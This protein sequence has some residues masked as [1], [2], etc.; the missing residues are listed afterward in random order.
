[1]N[2]LRS[3]FRAKLVLLA[4]C[5]LASGCCSN[6]SCCSSSCDSCS[7]SC[8]SFC[9]AGACDSGCASCGY[10]WWNPKSW[11]SRV[12]AS[13]MQ[14]PDVLPLGSV[15]RAHWDVMQTNGEA[16]DFV[17]YR[18]EFVDNSSELSPYGRDHIQEIAARMPS[19]PFPILVQRSW[20]NA[21][22]ELDQVRRDI[23]VRVLTALGN[24]DANQRVVVSQ[25]YSNGLNSRESELD[26][27]RFRSRGFGNG[28]G[29]GGNGGGGGGNGGGGF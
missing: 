6:T 16:G 24:Q 8:E 9:G 29:G 18:N 1:M 2:F 13:R 26:F 19:T 14:V 20:N 28:G 7:T 5:G 22:P 17:M 21:D 12:A 27:A 4:A 11:C 23:V 10:H 15:T 25:P 3:S